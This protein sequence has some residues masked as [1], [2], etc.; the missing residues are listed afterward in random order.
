MGQQQESRGHSVEAQRKKAILTFGLER[1]GQVDRGFHSSGYEEY[2]ILGY[3]A[4]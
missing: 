4:V 2:Y 3:N 1:E